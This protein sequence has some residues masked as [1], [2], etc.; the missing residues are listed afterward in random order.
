MA[1]PRTRAAA[2]VHDFEVLAAFRYAMRQF[3][4]F[5]EQAARGQGLTPQQHQA[6]L[7]VRAFPGGRI[8]IGELAERLQVRHHSAV[9]M[10]D[11]LTAL[12]LAS[13]TPADDDRRKVYIVLSARGP[14]A[15]DALA[16]P[17]RDELKRLGPQLRTLLDQLVRPRRR[18]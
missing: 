2:G 16:N 6:L 18:G 13:R 15:L 10:V 17:H 1:K 8:T 5:S 11:R 9:G 12:G 7:A 3:L 14:K 4:R